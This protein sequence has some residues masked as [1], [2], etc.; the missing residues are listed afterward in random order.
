MTTFLLFQHPVVMKLST[1]Q[2]TSDCLEILPDHFWTLY[3]VSGKSIYRTTK[4]Q[5]FYSQS[6]HS[7]KVLTV[8]IALSQFQLRN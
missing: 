5:D 8:Q 3:F 1:L 2:G 4:E 7:A 6:F